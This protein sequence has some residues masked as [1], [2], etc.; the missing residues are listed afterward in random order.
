[1]Q[2]QCQ[3]YID[4][5]EAEYAIV[6]VLLAPTRGGMRLRTLRLER[7]DDL[8]AEVRVIEG[9]F[10]ERVQTGDA[11]PVDGD[12]RTGRL[13]S[14]M[15]DAAPDS[16]VDLDDEHAEQVESIR[17]AYAYA[18]E[19]EKHYEGLKRKAQHQ[20]LLLLG[21]KQIGRLHGQVA[22]KRIDVKPT[23]V[24]ATTRAGYSRVHFP[25]AKEATK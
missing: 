4:V 22:I 21:D 25:K 17:K 14:R 19:Q 16:V 24:P 20:A 13:I 5:M 10:W 23:E 8:I 1:V 7:D 9:E 2:L 15:Y 12:K 11:P 18:A 6:C 3:H